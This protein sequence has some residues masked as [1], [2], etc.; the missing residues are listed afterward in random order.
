MVGFPAMVGNANGYTFIFYPWTLPTVGGLD[1]CLQCTAVI[2][3]L[4]VILSS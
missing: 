1:Y 4:H 2:D 3:K